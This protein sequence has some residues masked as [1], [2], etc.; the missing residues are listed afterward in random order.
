MLSLS[1]GFS[2]RLAGNRLP[3]DGTPSLDLDFTAQPVSLDLDFTT[4]SYRIR[5]VE[6]TGDT[7]GDFKIW[8]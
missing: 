8:G 1:L 2:F 7:A 5:P 3:V 4:Q 6:I